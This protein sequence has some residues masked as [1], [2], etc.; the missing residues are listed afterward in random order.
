M[1]LDP[2]EAQTLAKVPAQ[3]GSFGVH[4]VGLH[5]ALGLFSK[6]NS[7]PEQCVASVEVVPSPL[8]C[9]TSPPLQ[10]RVLGTQAISTQAPFWHC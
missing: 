8:H 1:G 7:P 2:S 5:S 6:Q 4:C 9:Q 3:T 10:N